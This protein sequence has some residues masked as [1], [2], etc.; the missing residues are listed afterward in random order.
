MPGGLPLPPGM[1]LPGPMAHMGGPRPMHMGGPLPRPMP[2]GMPGLAGNMRP[3]GIDQPRMPPTEGQVRV[4]DS[5]CIC[6]KLMHRP[7]RHSSTPLKAMW[8]GVQRGMLN[9]QPAPPLRRHQ[10]EP[11]QWRGPPSGASA[12]PRDMPGPH[13]HGAPGMLPMP[14]MGDLFGSGGRGGGG[15]GPQQRGPGG[16]MPM[17]Q[18]QQPPAGLACTASC[19]S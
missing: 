1:M 18:Q 16:F 13:M 12:P 17:P 4:H 5:G 15:G 6:P 7:S 19:I 10:H 9:G 11:V 14:P 8:L 2:G 3:L